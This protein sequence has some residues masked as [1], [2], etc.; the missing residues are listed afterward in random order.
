MTS[1]QETEGRGSILTTPEPAWGL[2]TA[3]KHDSRHN[4]IT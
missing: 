2:I 4:K 1:G 3:D